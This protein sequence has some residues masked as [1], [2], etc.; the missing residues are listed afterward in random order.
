MFKEFWK[1]CGWLGKIAT[2]ISIII[3]VFAHI[4]SIYCL[5]DAEWVAAISIVSPILPRIFLVLMLIACVAL[6][7]MLITARWF[8]DAL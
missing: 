1:S 4:F 8:G 5:I 6:D 7:M 3:V 2:I